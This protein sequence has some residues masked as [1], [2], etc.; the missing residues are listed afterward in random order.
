MSCVYNVS[1]CL[2][3][4]EMLV[5]GVRDAAHACGLHV[6]VDGARLFNA[7]TALSCPVGDIADFVDSG[8]FCLSK[9][10]GA[11]V[12][13]VVF[14]S[15]D[16]IAKARAMRKMVG[17]GMRQ[18][19]VIAAAG[20]YALDHNVTRLA[21]DHAN[22]RELAAGLAKVSGIRILNPEVES[23][24]VY[25]QVDGSSAWSSK[26]SALEEQDP[27]SAET[28]ALTRGLEEVGIRVGGGYGAGGLRLVTHKDVTAADVA[29]LVE[30]VDL[31]LN[32]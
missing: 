13:S 24:I 12:G 27:I 26:Q 11:P 18:A 10:L 28:A 3:A 1:S 22:A 6:H 7:A 25:V 2:F 20:L 8:T 21:E 16:M 29:H 5:T 15:S 31:V 17:G 9:G 19:G 14:G 4:T 32:N 30:T 23:N